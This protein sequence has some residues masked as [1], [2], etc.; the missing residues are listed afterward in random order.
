MPK[1][2]DFW[3]DRFA[4]E[5]YIYGETP[6]AFVRAAADTWCPGEQDILVLGAGEGRNAVFLAQQG[7]A[8]TAVDYSAEGLRKTMRLAGAADV[9]VTT[10]EAD[11][12]EW[13]PD[14]TWDA[15]VTTFLH[16]PPAD[17]PGLYALIRRCL[18]PGG[19]LVAEWFR[20]EQRTE[21]YTSGGPPDADMM[22]TP[23]ELREHFSGEGIEQLDVAEPTLN[24]GMH[25]GP[26]ATVQ[27][28]W[29][30]PE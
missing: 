29:R 18:R 10:L 26:G 19:H 17:R 12:R 5:E 22:V 6:N 27:F 30:R 15:V 28:V 13:T 9:D 16:L 25:Q 23:A 1:P 11:V 4:A 20:P 14:R 3:N 7:H 24:E 8:V 21:G 2:A